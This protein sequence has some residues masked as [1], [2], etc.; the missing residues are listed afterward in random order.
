MFRETLEDH[1]DVIGIACEGK[2]TEDDMKRIHA[3][4]HETLAAAGQPG[5]VID[6]TGFDGFESPSAL[7]EDVR[8]ETA[9]R[10]DFSRIA[11]IGDRKWI[12]WGT[13]LAKALTRSEMQ[14]FE[15]HDRNQAT[16]W[17]GGG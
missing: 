15:P 3:L 13:S 1:D 12:E 17:A 8:M 9:H 7:R 16:D 14:W 11:V 5:M 2:L 4:L 10:N 6:L